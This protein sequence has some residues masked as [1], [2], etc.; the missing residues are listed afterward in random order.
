[1]VRLRHHSFYTL[2]LRWM[3][4]L[5]VVLFSNVFFVLFAFPTRWFSFS[6]LQLLHS[7]ATSTGM[8]LT[9]GPYY[10]ELIRACI[11]SGAYAL[12]AVLLLLTPGLGVWKSLALFVIGSVLLLAMNVVRIVVLVE[13]LYAYGTNLFSAVHLTFWF[14]MSSVFV[15]LVWIALIKKFRIVAVPAYDD[16]RFVYLTL[17][18]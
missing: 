15:A 5:A 11:A 7:T 13:V 3:L 8:I 10:V 1:M 2:A 4:A 12:L 18:R 16:L 14:L 17:R 9:I 6:W